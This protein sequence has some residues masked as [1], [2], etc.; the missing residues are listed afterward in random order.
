MIH[1]CGAGAGDEYVRRNFRLINDQHCGDQ[2]VRAYVARIEAM[3]A[4]FDRLAVLQ[5]D[6]K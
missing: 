3:R 4:Q 1:L 6:Q 5:D 2:D